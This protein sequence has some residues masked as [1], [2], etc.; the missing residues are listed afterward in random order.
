MTI[1]TFWTIVIKMLGIWL[2]L[3]FL[4]VIPQ[5][6]SALTYFGANRNENLFAIV[7]VIVLFLLTIGIYTFILR[8]FVFKTDW[9]IVK[10][11]LDKGFIEEKIELNIP[12]STVLT[13]ATI[14][15]GGIV[16]VEG[17]S[18]LFKQIFVFIQQDNRFSESPNSGWIIFYFAKTILGYLLMT[19]SLFVV[20]WID[21]QNQKPNDLDK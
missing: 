17:L 20:K 11:H 6:I 13:I 4:T 21:T 7:Y 18:Q 14:V 19:N 8:L 1:K 12:H 2:G 3:G 16:F 5:F 10:L 15:I 9:L